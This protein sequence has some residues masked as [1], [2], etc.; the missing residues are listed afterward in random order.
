MC[1]SCLFYMDK[2]KPMS[3][4]MSITEYT[5]SL[6]PALQ[7]PPLIN[8]V[9]SP[10]FILYQAFQMADVLLNISVL[11]LFVCETRACLCLPSSSG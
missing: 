2:G 5:K 7:Q 6:F 11:L 10:D 3:P 8:S 9:C 1:Y 4:P